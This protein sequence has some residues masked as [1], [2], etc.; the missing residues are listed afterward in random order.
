M[1]SSRI[2]LFLLIIL[3]IAGCGGGGSSTG[4]GTVST[5]GGGSTTGPG[6]GGS[7]ITGNNVLSITVNGSLC[8]PVTSASYPNKPCVSITVCNPSGSSTCQMIDDILLDTG[9]FGLRIFKSILGPAMAFSQVAAGSGSL[10]ECAQFGDGSS[11][12]GPVQLAGVALASEPTVTV[13]IQIIDSTFAISTSLTSTICPGAGQDPATAGFNGILGVGV[14]SLDCGSACTN[15]ALNGLYYSCSGSACNGTTVALTD[16]VQNPVALLPQDNN[17]VIV[18]LP[19]VPSSGTSSVAGVLVLGIG[20][21]TNNVPSGVSRYPTDQSGDII[22]T[23]SGTTATYSSVIDS[24][25]NGLFFT[26]LSASQLPDCPSPNAGWFCPSS[27]V[28][29]SATNAGASG[30]PSGV[31]SFQIGNFNSLANSSNRVFSN[32]GGNTPGMFDWGLPFYFGRDVYVGIDGKGSSLGTG[33]YW[34]Y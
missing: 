5:G 9:S 18:M 33:P 13:P 32:I 16:Q 27:T 8:S 6:S 20:T 4:S 12:W 17:G 30:L 24:G 21:Q 23:I 26:P 31:V 19:S 14:F 29:L 15:R 2:S 11:L 28:S 10:A 22:T 34:G 25:S 1:I 3:L 7:G